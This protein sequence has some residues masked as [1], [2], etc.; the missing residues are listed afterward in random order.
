MVVVLGDLIADLAIHIPSFPVLAQDLKPISYLE[1]GPGGATNIAIMAARFGLPVACLGEVGRDSFGDT[2]R[3][4]LEREGIRTANMISNPESKTPVAGVIVD[5]RREPAYLGYSGNL[6]V[7]ALP[8]EWEPV[9]TGADTLFADGWVEIPEMPHMILDAFRLARRAGVKTYFDPGPGNPAFDLGWHVE[10]AELADVLLVNEQEA[11]RIAD[12]DE[13]HMA[14]RFL[15]KHGSEMV[16]LK[17]GARGMTLFSRTEE[18]HASGYKVEPLDFTGAGDSVT[19]AVL[20]GLA[21]GLDLATIGSLANATGAAKV[22]KR[23]TG[24]N[25]PTL[26]EIRAVLARFAPEH[27][28][29]L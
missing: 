26:D 4:G 29:L 11:E 3:A 15:V 25:M 17:Q 20:Y 1:I 10:A 18:V 8:G 24:L 21:K 28:R 9:I 19:G 7:R 5:E 14:A 22:Q 23:G 12:L 13:P 16:V 2:V 6:T 27:A